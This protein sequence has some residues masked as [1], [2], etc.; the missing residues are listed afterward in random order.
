M[1]ALQQLGI[2]L[3]LTDRYAETKRL[4]RD[5]IQRQGDI[6]GHWDALPVGYYFACVAAA[7]N[8]PDDALQ[9]LREAID[10][11]FKETVYLISEPDLKKLH[12]NPKFQQLVAEL[13]RA[14]AKD[15]KAQTQ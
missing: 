9:F 1:I 13:K 7:S 15:Q 4:F 11:G 12:P 8:H 10:N 14:P 5:V 3:A 2:V 6:Q